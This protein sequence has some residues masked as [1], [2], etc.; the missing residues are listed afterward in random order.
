M[1]WF[2]CDPESSTRSVVISQ[3]SGN[4]IYLGDRSCG[5]ETPAVFKAWY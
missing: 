5:P 2:I 1:A 3:F 4:F